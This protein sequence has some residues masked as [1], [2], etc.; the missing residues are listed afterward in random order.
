MAGSQQGDGKVVARTLRP[1][2]GESSLIPWG[3][4]VNFTL[5]G[6]IAGCALEVDAISR[7]MRFAWV[8]IGGGKTTGGNFANHRIAIYSPADPLSPIKAGR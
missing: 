1:R 3:M 2:H 4:S 8:L 7:G 6:A 5:G